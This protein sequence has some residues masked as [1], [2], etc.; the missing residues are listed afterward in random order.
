MGDDDE[1]DDDDER[2]PPPLPDM[3]ILWMVHKKKKKTSFY[4]WRE[5][6][7]FLHTLKALCVC[8]LVWKE[9]IEWTL[10]SQRAAV[11]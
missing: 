3:L 7:L 2:G 10:D 5:Y 11:L 8:V 1:E 4:I 9:G 6:I